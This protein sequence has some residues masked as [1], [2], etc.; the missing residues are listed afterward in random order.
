MLDLQE[1]VTKTAALSDAEVNSY[2]DNF[3]QEEIR[4]LAEQVFRAKE[5]LR[6]EQQLLFYQP[7]SDEAKRFHFS[8]AQQ[9]VILGGNG[10]SK[11]ETNLVDM[12]IAMTGIVPYSLQADYPKEKLRPPI[13]SRLIVESL[14]NTWESS[15][16]PKLQWDH[17]TGLIDG[18]R[19]HFG[20]IPKQFLIRGKWEESWSE[21]YRTLRL[22]NGSTL[23]VMSGDQ[24]VSD[25]ASASVHDIRIDEGKTHP[26]YRENLMRLREGGYI[27]MAM[28]P[29]DEES[30]SWDAAWVYDELYTN[31]LPGPNKRPD[32]DAFTFF[33]EHNKNL[34]DDFITK[35]GKNLTPTQKEVRFHGHFMHLGGRIYPTYTDRAQWWCFQ[36]NRITTTIKDSFWTLCAT[37]NGNDV[38]EFQ[39]FI[40]PFD[41]VY[42]WP[43][44]YALDPHERKPH[45]M[46]WYAISPEDDVYQIK[47]MEIDAE[48]EVVAEKVFE[49]ENNMDIQIVKRI[50]D[51]KTAGS[52][53]SITGR[54]GRTVRQEFD[55]VKLHCDLADSNRDTARNQLRAMLKPDFMT[56]RPRFFVFNTCARTNYMMNR[57]VWGNWARYSEGT[58]NPKAIPMDINDD[59]PALAQYM[60]NLQPS[61]ANIFSMRTPFVK[62]GRRRAY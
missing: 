40:E 44:I 35:I 21:K 24:D 34:A 59:F 2:L 22:V 45:C 38:V 28:T 9:R 41:D 56:K 61:Y 23:Q 27:S 18:R 16:K 30:S 26:L 11:T 13:A 5:A 14:T 50:I 20:W 57:Y 36:C 19:G 7:V 29:P 12:A 4:S 48:V 17:W 53:P 32:I 51:P 6:Q 60:A 47:E 49:W 1:A 31:G 3:S 52:A 58:K 55:N 62:P 25:F 33:T 37:C 8:T 39:H 46:A 15:I 54:R 43:V 10:S 42:R